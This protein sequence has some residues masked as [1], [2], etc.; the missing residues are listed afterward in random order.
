MLG[1]KIREKRV[2]KKMSLKRLAEKTA[3]TASFLSQVERDLA[4]PSITSLRKIAEALEVPI[5]YFL[6]DR[7][8]TS[9]VVRRNER[10]ILKIPKSNLVFELLSP[11]LNRQMEVMIARLDVGA[12]S[13][14]EPLS[15]EGEELVFILAGEMEIT[16]GEEQF[17]LKKGDSIYY[18][19]AIPHKLISVGDEELVFLSA[20]TP[21][22]F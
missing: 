19:A 18:F 12:A 6:L 11:D 16:I 2:E 8:N 20:I 13:C 5:F 21:P 10:K 14:D 9:P 7:K 1:S 17:L 3:L 15:H 22:R 4:E